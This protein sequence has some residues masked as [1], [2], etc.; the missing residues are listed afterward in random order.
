M[1]AMRWIPALCLTMLA[2]AAWADTFYVCRKGGLTAFA[3]S[4]TVQNYKH[5][6]Y[7]CTARMQF[8]DRRPA[9]S[10][11]DGGGDL[12]PTAS[13][14]PRHYGGPAG[15]RESFE[16]IIQEAS[17]RFKVPANLVRAVIRVESDYHPQAVSS[18]GAQG[19]MQLMPD[20]ATTLGVSD[21]F[22]PRQNIMAGARYLR[23]LINRFNGDP[24]LTLAAY[25]AGPSIVESRGEIPFRATEEYV[26]RVLTHFYRYKETRL[27]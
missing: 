22:D 2:S 26:R 23:M 19:L 8:E 14:A 24:K 5:Q 1:P 25:H 21:A 15:E 17:E 16:P 3:N 13:M 7:R 11:R 9:P 12:P 10:A 6:G 4:P 20:T 18:A 27:P